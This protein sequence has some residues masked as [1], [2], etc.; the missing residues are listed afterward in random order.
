MARGLCF[1]FSMPPWPYRSPD[2]V[3]MLRRTL[4]VLADRRRGGF[5]GVS[6]IAPAPAHCGTRRCTNTQILG[7]VRCR[8]RG[9][10][11]LAR[12][13]A[14]PHSHLPVACSAR[15]A[16]E[17]ASR[18]GLASHVIIGQALRITPRLIV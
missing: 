13:P 11:Q 14:K 12:R 4:R 9:Q 10:R 18:V 15:R 17:M 16:A 7:G 6:L 1:D 3:D 8:P 5:D 2:L